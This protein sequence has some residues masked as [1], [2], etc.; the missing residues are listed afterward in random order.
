MRG[1]FRCFGVFTGFVF[2]NYV[3]NVQKKN[4]LVKMHRLNKIVL[5]QKPD[6]RWSVRDLRDIWYEKKN[7]NYTQIV[8]KPLGI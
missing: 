5:R 7:N 8:V 3:K 4:R 2:E 1:Y 6:H